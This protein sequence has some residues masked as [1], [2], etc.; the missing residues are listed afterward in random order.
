MLR[1]LK[2]LFRKPVPVRASWEQTPAKYV[3]RVAFLNWFDNT[4]SIEDT[5]RRSA[6]DWQF[7]FADHAEY[8]KIDKQRALEIGFGAGRLLM[9]AGK[10]FEQ[11]IGVDIHVA[12]AE[13]ANF[14]RSQGCENFSLLH[15][16][17]LG[18]VA[19]SSVDFVYSFIVFQHFD[20]MDEVRYYLGHIA[21]CLKPSGYAHIYFGRNDA[22]GVKVV[23]EAEFKLRD[24]S[25]LI[26]PDLMAQAIAETFDIIDV[27]D[28][29]PK[30]PVTRQGRSGQFYVKFRRRARAG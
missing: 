3:D 2:K 6:A 23:G 10:D 26:E 25:L 21:R 28:N 13:T 11:V 18:A 27:Q 29:L 5:L 7:R 15:R 17:E 24:R 8:Q 9:Q 12:F 16:D 19:Q 14:L 20:S 4:A 1:T 30:D 22:P